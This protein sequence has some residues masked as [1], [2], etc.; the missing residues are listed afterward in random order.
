MRLPHIATKVRSKPATIWVASSLIALVNR[1]IYTLTIACIPDLLQRVLHEPRS[2]NGVITAAF[3]VGGLVAGCSI[4]YISDRTQNRLVPQLVAAALYVV[5]G[6]VFF[7]AK[8]FHQIVAFRLILGA[9]SSIADTMLFTTVADVYPANLLG[10]KMAVLFVFDNIG[11]ML[12]PLLGG[13]AYEKMGVG[14][15]AI[16]AMGLGVAEFL[17]ILLFVRNSLDIRQTLVRNAASSLSTS[18]SD[19]RVIESTIT[20]RRPSTSDHP[21]EK[22]GAT[23]CNS[24]VSISSTGSTPSDSDASNLPTSKPEVISSASGAHSSLQIVRLLLQLPVVGPTV[25]IF[26][27]TGMQ[28]VIETVFPLRLYDKFGDSP[29]DIGIAFMIV[30]GVLILA[31]PAVG[32][33]NDSVISRHGER[34]RYYTIAVGVLMMLVSL[35]VTAVAGSY[36]VLIF[37]YALFSI[38]SMLVIVPAQSAFGDYINSTGSHAMAQCYS[39]AWI[40][41]GMANISL[42]PIASGLYAIIGFLR[43]LMSM[44]TVLCTICAISVLAFPLHC[45]WRARRDE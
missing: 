13:K 23:T 6:V 3:G 20:S 21:S 40:A 32:Y 8:H 15:I 29:G 4:G 9:A 5:A 35:S 19:L 28:S 33:I 22:V 42:P 37:G 34:M 11:N 2:S 26:V 45:Y 31:M 14:G 38:T 10:F 16:I 43:M 44:S 7:Y 39:L 27:G 18:A 17:L 12:G 1:L 36:P 25:S 30:G 41:E 24:C